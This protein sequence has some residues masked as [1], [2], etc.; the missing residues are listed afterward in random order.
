VRLTSI[1]ELPRETVRKGRLMTPER[2]IVNVR[3]EEIC[4][5]LVNYH[6]VILSLSVH[7]CVPYM[8]SGLPIGEGNR[9]DFY[10]A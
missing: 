9:F 5:C 6:S 3:Q 7:L 10:R 1:Y 8:W 4:V 2:I